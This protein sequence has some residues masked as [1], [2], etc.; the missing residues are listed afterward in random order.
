MRS[1]APTAAP[2]AAGTGT[3]AHNSY[4]EAPLSSLFLQRFPWLLSLML[5][6]SISGYVVEQ[7]SA[8]VQRHVVLASF[9]T[10]LVGGGGN[11]SGQTVADLVKRQASGE[12]KHGDM[13]RVL[14]REMCLGG[15]LALALGVCAYPRVRLL[16][17]NASTLD[18][19]TIAAAYTT[20]V[21]M[22]NAVGVLVVMTLHRCDLAAVGSPPVV[23]V[24]VDV[25][26]V[27][28]TMIIAQAILPA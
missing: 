21:F 1:D 4:F 19:L 22:A 13:L 12:I 18:A 9:L 2:S 26:G 17:E 14:I 8:L 20:I 7:F 24:V 15:M 6:Q 3:T 25:L 5:V 27:T 28:I 11:S 10:M 16:S 23:Q